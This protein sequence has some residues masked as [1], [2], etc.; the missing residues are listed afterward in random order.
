MA[1]STKD[2]NELLLELNLSNNLLTSLDVSHLTS[3]EGLDCSGNQLTSLD[4]SNNIF[5]VSI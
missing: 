5:S 4:V 2:P 1:N 3:L